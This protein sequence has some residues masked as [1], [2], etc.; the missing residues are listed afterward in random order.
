MHQGGRFF[1]LLGSNGNVSYLQYTGI[2][3]IIPLTGIMVCGTGNAWY[4]KT[5]I[6]SWERS[7]LVTLEDSSD[8]RHS[9]LLEP[10]THMISAWTA[11]RMN[12]AYLSLSDLTSR[13]LS[14]LAG[15]EFSMMLVADR[16]SPV[17]D[18]RVV[19][20]YRSSIHFSE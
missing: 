10:I 16:G 9:S 20:G 4:A 3:R 11:A 12:W 6:V 19:D 5:G 15:H 14:R 7:Y 18:E 2:R 1:L 17:V 13:S 8:I